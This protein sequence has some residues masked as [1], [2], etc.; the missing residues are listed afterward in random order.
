MYSLWSPFNIFSLQKYRK[1]KIQKEQS[2]TPTT[3]CSV[4]DH[5]DW[6]RYKQR[7]VSYS[8]YNAKRLSITDADDLGHHL[9]KF[10]PTNLSKN[11]IK[12]KINVSSFG[13]WNAITYNYKAC[14]YRFRQTIARNGNKF[15]AY[16]LSMLRWIPKRLYIA[17]TYAKSSSTTSELKNDNDIHGLLNITLNYNFKIHSI[18][19]CKNLSNASSLR[20]GNLACYLSTSDYLFNTLLGTR[21]ILPRPSLVCSKKLT[22]K[23]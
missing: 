23:K 17:D 20:L 13:V 18:Y 5:I 19:E 12:H 15:E 22:Q 16:K 4:H 7:N 9:R 2:S 6:A 21:I 14:E 8:V 3:G 1:K 10:L 11:Y